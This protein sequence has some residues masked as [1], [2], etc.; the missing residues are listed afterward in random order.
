MKIKT[1][2]LIGLIGLMYSLLACRLEGNM[3]TIR[4]S[5]R[6]APYKVTFN[7][8]NSDAGSTEAFP[9]TRSIPIPKPDPNFPYLTEYKSTVSFY[10]GMPLPPTRIGYTFT[11]WNTKADGSGTAFTENTAVKGNIT[12]YAQWV[13]WAEI[14][15]EMAAI[16]AGTFMMGSPG[17][18]PGRYT[19]ETQYQVTLSAFNICKYQVTQEFYQLVMGSNPSYFDS[20]PSSGEVQGRRPVE[21]VSWYNAVSFCNEL[22]KLEGLNPAYTI[23]GTDVTWNRSANGYRLPTEAEWEYACRAGTTT[24]F[25]NGVTQNWQNSAAVN[26]LGW[27]SSNSGSR[28]HEVGKKQANK[29]GLYDMHGN[30]YEWCW[31]WYGTYPNTAETDPAGPSSGSYRVRRGGGWDSIAQ[32]ARSAYRVYGNPSNWGY[33]IGF[34]L[35]CP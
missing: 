4:G 32:N 21:N 7:K 26:E 9:R 16:P 27:Y 6:L 11:G 31:D 17:T 2:T 24:A 34:R 8:N 10:S 20:N 25:N 3:A 23:S 12:V 22:S 19:D 29:W 35:A 15:F 5:L 1:K 18:E 28:T 14:K 30:V 33:R 13:Q